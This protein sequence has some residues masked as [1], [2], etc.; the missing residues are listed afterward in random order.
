MLNEEEIF[1]LLN[2]GADYKLSEKGRQE[3]LAKISSTYFKCLVAKEFRWLNEI[4]QYLIVLSFN[5]TIF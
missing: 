2:S 4:E 3:L 1:Y 5:E